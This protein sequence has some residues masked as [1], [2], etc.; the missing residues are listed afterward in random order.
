MQKYLDD[1]NLP[2]LSQEDQDFL[3]AEITLDEINETI[4]KLKGGKTPGPDGLPYEIYRLFGDLLSPYMLKMFTQALNDGCLPQTL[5]EAII[6]VLPKKGKDTKEVGGYRPISLL[7]VD[8]KVLAKTLANR[9]SRFLGKL[10]QPDQTGF[11][12]G[13]N[14]FCNLRCLFSIMYSSQ[15][16]NTDLVVISLDAEKAFDQVEW[17]YLFAVLQ[18]FG[19]G[20]AVI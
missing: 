13:R 3:G 5:N 2:V 11:M 10:I 6:T 1:C 9:L 12:P 20:E 14:S 7:N 8:Q 18:K 19:L 15:T 16:S 4:Q 17:S